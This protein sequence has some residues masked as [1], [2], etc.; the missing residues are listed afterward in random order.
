MRQGRI[1]EG[2]RKGGEKEAGRRQEQREKGHVIDVC[3]VAVTLS[4]TLVYFSIL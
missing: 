4:K 1:W 2:K 3:T